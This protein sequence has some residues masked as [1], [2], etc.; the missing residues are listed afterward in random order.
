MCFFLCSLS[1]YL[2]SQLSHISRK[3]GKRRVKSRSGSK[4]WI[5]RECSWEGKMIDGENE[6]N[7]RTKP[8]EDVNPVRKVWRYPFRAV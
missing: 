4:F 3:R 6:E 1:M 7:S 8:V 5:F 2:T